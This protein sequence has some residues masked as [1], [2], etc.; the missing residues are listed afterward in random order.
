MNLKYLAIA[1]LALTIGSTD[2]LAQGP[3]G[4][5]LGFGLILIDPL[6]AT[7]KIWTNP[8]NAFVFDIGGDDFGPIRLDGDYL[9][10]FDPFRS[11]IVKMYAG[12][13]LSLAFGN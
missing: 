8:V 1:I 10:H 7:V 13:G 2:C 4:K 12:P 3:G 5:D 11:R 6:G 9:W